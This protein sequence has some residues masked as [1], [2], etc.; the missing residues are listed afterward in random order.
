M[1]P[2][3]PFATLILFVQKN[4]KS[5]RLYEDYLAFNKLTVK[6]KFPMPYIEYILERLNGTK[7][8]SKIDLKSGYHLN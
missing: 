3:S 1:Q 6:N 8:F 5:A 7:Y 2:S 4:N